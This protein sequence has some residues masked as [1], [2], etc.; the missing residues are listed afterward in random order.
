MAL[1]L[2]A[3]VGS[4]SA[5]SYCT[6][7]EALAFAAEIFPATEVAPFLTASPDD[8]ARAL[9]AAARRIDEERFVGDRVDEIQGLHWPRYGALKADRV[10]PYLNT[11]IPTALKRAQATLAAFLVKQAVAGTTAL[12][13]SRNAG[14]TSISFGSELAMTFSEGQAAIPAGERF[15]AQVIRPLLG[16][17][18]VSGQPRMV[19]G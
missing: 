5:N 1:I 18:V 16:G 9:L 2:V 19:R 4:A 11:E 8:Q 6:L 10:T 17:L 7:A 15:M 3:T 12:G 13:P 14:L